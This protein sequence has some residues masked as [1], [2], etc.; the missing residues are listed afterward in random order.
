MDLQIKIQTVPFF[1]L[2]K[3]NHFTAGETLMTEGLLE[4]LQL[5]QHQKLLHGPA[6][7]GLTLVVA[8]TSDSWWNCTWF[9]TIGL[10]Y[11]PVN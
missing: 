3:E 8:K 7:N 4:M 10:K 11:S 6:V 2:G 1:E 5:G 9:E